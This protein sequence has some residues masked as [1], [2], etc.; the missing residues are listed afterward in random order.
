[1]KKYKIDKHMELGLYRQPDINFQ[2]PKS[3]GT[4]RGMYVKILVAVYNDGKIQP[5]STT[6]SHMSSIFQVNFVFFQP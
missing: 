4:S 5:T 2:G 1:M 6:A 3:K